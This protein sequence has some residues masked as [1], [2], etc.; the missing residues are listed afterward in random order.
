M[1]TQGN[2]WIVHHRN[3]HL[4]ACNLVNPCH[5]TL[6]I[7]KRKKI[8]CQFWGPFCRNALFSRCPFP[9]ATA[10]AVPAATRSSARRATPSFSL[11]TEQVPSQPPAS[12]WPGWRQ[13]T[14]SQPALRV[15]FIFNNGDVLLGPGFSSAVRKAAFFS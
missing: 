11:K 6:L 5:P 3:A 7:L 15:L 13:Q 12:L 9:R 2:V 1:G 10:A 4:K 8:F 14:P